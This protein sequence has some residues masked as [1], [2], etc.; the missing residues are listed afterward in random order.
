MVVPHR[1]VQAERLVPLA[2]AVSGTGV[3]LDDDGRHVE[4]TQPRAERDPALAAADDDHLGL[5]LATEA[6]LLVDA[7]LGPAPARLDRAVIDAPG[8]GGATTLLV[9]LE[10]GQRGQERPDPAVADADVAVPAAGFGLEVDPGLQEAAAVLGVLAG[11]DRPSARRDVRE[12]G[13]QHLGDL[14]APFHRADVPGEA[15]QIAPVAVGLEQGGGR[16]GVVG[17][18]RPVEI[19]ENLVDRSGGRRVEHSFL[20]PVRRVSDALLHL[21]ALPIRAGATTV[22]MAEVSRTGR[23]AAPPRISE[24]LAPGG[25]R[26][27]S[28]TRARGSRRAACSCRRCGRAA[29]SGRGGGPRPRCR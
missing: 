18:E 13:A 8:P 10:L 17:C 20:P 26:A 25:G 23:I 16:L 12:L 4:L 5:H 22:L 3:A 9:A 7:A 27:S 28:G 2:P 29:R 6:R 24:S 14:A 15:R 11:G 21:A 19:G 1:V